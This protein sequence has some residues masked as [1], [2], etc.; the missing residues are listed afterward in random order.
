MLKTRWSQCELFVEF[1][2]PSKKDIYIFEKIENKIKGTELCLGRPLKY[3]EALFE[4]NGFRLTQINFINI[5]VSFFV[6]GI[7][8]KLFN[9]PRRKEGE[10]ISKLSQ[11][12]QKITL[13][14]TSYLD[15]IFKSR[16]ELC[17]LHFTKR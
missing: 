17:M 2:N 9:N 16:R 13:P 6:S 4:K 7:I 1:F 8:R 14:I 10:E 3:Y 11:F 12:L 15:D 5:R